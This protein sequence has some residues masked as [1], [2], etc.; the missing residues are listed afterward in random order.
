[1][2]RYRNAKRYMH[3]YTRGVAFAHELAQMHPFTH[4]DGTCVFVLAHMCAR[5]CELSHFFTMIFHR[6][7]AGNYGPGRSLEVLGSLRRS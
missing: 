2:H 6:I 7:L 4:V 5:A 1:M 3:R